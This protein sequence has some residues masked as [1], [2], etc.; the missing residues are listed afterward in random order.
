MLVAQRQIWCITDGTSLGT[1]WAPGTD[2]ASWLAWVEE[3][4]LPAI[5]TD[6]DTLTVAGPAEE[7]VIATTQVV[8]ITTSLGVVDV[9]VTGADDVAVCDDASGAVLDGSQLTVASPSEPVELCVTRETPGEITVT[10]TSSR[11]APSSI[12]GYVDDGCQIFFTESVEAYRLT[13]SAAAT[14]VVQQATTTTT[15][16]STTTTTTT[17]TL[18]PSTTSTTT[19]TPTTTTAVTTT[20]AATTTSSAVTSTTAALSVSRYASTLSV[21]KIWQPSST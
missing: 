21:K 3:T 7:A 18:P 5:P 11:Y 4:V 1:E 10:A 8:T 9:S 2:C 14:F 16:T 6:G 12:I 15:T 13:D 20:T 17:T 19:A